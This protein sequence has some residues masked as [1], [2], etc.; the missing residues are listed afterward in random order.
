MRLSTEDELAEEVAQGF[1]V[2]DDD[3]LKATNVDL[4]ESKNRLNKYG[5]HEIK[6]NFSMD[7]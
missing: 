7:V 6:I 5:I 2:V 1:E 4:S 3:S